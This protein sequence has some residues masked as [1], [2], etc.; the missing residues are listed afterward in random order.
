MKIKINKNRASQKV[1]IKID[2]LA[3]STKEAIAEGF[4][5]MGSGLVKT[6]QDS[7]LNEPKFGRE[8]RVKDK[9]G[10]RRL[11]R[12][13]GSNQTPA[14]ITGE[15]FEGAFYKPDGANGLEFGD[16]TE[17]AGFLELGTDKMQPRPGLGNAITSS[18]RN[19]RLYLEKSLES[20]FKP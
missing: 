4:E 13:S 20:G 18:L 17:Y 19:S 7:I 1:V 8:Y 11:H 2:G 6:L 16:T 10:V 15:Y 9:G 14:L 3:N 5:K 12:A